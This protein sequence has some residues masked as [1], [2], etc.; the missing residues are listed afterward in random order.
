[1]QI[2]GG[3]YIKELFFNFGPYNFR[4]RISVGII[5]LA[6]W[7]LELYLL[8]P[9]IH[10]L[11]STLIIAIIIYGIC[12]LVIV[13]CRIPGVKA[14]KKCFPYLLPAQEFLLPSSSKIDTVTKQRY[15]KFLS[16]HI[17]EFKISNNDT[18]M[19]P[20][21]STAVTWLISKTRD[22]RKFPLI[23]EE[24]ANFGFSYNLLG[25]KTYGI[26]ISCI[27]LIANAILM[28]LFFTNSISINISRIL[29][30]FVLHF[31]FL[32]LWIFII[33][34]KLVVSSGQKYA[35][36]L[37]SACDSNDID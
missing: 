7:L 35:R 36:A 22:S 31:L 30:G 11:S 32:L 5:F 12:N 9:E 34:K 24:N 19:F 26:T 15:Y 37:L 29:V 20:Y 8:I 3:D 14:M 17:D 10:D 28:Y 25:L 27:G 13:Y 18:E 6:P 1:M 2:I 16:E 4:A 23:A 33:T 21:V